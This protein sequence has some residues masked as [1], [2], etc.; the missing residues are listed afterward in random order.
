MSDSSSETSESHA[1]DY[2]PTILEFPDATIDAPRLLKLDPSPAEQE[3]NRQKGQ[4][5]ANSHIDDLMALTGLEKVKSESLHTTLLGNP[6]VGKTTVARIYASIITSIGAVTGS[7]YHECTGSSPGYLVDEV[8]SMLRCSDGGVVF[9]DETY[10]LIEQENYAIMNFIMHAM[11]EHRGK[12]VFI[13]AGYEDEMD[14][15]YRF[16]QGFKERILFTFYFEDFSDAGLHKI[17]VRNIRTRW[18]GRMGIQHGLNGVNTRILASRVGL[19]RGRRGHG[20]ARTLENKFAEAQLRQ[21]DR[22]EAARRSGRKPND[23]FMI[24]EDVI[25]PEPVFAFDNSK[26]FV[27][28]QTMVGLDNIKEQIKGFAG[29]LYTNYLREPEK[30]PPVQ[31][32]L[33]QVFL[34]PPGTGKTT[35]AELYA[36]ILAELGLLSSGEVLLRNAGDFIGRY[37]GES[38]VKT[39]QILEAARGRV[40]V[41]DEMYM[42]DPTTRSDGINT[43]HPCPFRK[44]VIDTVVANVQN[45]PG[46][47]RCVI[48][49]GYTK[50]MEEMWAG[51][52]PG[53]SR[54]FPLQSAFQFSDFSDEE[55]MQIFDLK[56]RKQ[57]LTATKDARQTALEIFTLTRKRPNFGN[58]GEVENVITVAKANHEKQQ[59]K[60]PLA[61]RSA[62]I[63]LQ[64]V[65]FDPEFDRSGRSC[66]ELVGY[67]HLIAQF[68]KYHRIVANMK[69]R[70]MD[71][72]SFIPFTFV[73]KGP[74]GT[75]K[76][77][78]ARKIGQ[79]RYNM[80]L[81]ASNEVI[82]ASVKD[83]VAGYLGQ[84]AI[85]TNNLLTSALGKVLLIDEAYRLNPKSSGGG[86]G[87][88]FQQ[89]TLDQLVD[90]MT[91]PELKGKVIVVLAGYDNEM[92]EL[93]AASP[94]LS[95]RFATELHFENLDSKKC[96]ELL[97]RK[98]KGHGMVVE[99]TLDK[100]QEKQLVMHVFDLL[101][102]L[103]GWGNGRD[104]E[105]LAK[106][107][108]G[109]AVADADMSDLGAFM[110]KEKHIFQVMDELLGQRKAR[111]TAAGMLEEDLIL[112]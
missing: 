89:E 40:L 104:V 103:N 74:P 32:G 14:G 112:R 29:M 59:S 69:A 60:K 1:D 54:R 96:Y 48:L 83:M 109:A 23:F 45:R 53:L 65:D 76:T 98:L 9:V 58:G 21:A 86:Q 44:G 107:I 68:D 56:L 26:A 18:N 8:M 22:V 4:G 81:L 111:D 106:E 93:M 62:E 105:T 6:G 50:E 88:S 27:E 46:D 35:V 87:G 57:E 24:R 19:G 66:G 55:L 95:S 101:S 79:L 100:G 33:S 71:P 94:G 91:K 78:T 28:L 97:M 80:G 36:K 13:F 67:E 47:D 38:E 75:G 12:I 99:A 31:I 72:K 30:K 85:K 61:E 92:N 64:P 41:I 77:T 7:G 17:L 84:T 70:D 37:I 3:W 73:F 82:E 10:Q 102:Q 34:G 49:M 5:V 20:N 2:V 39:K 16:N 90:C 110:V 15:F 11:E 51:A 25:G 63:I 43:G 108:V 52:N 42:L